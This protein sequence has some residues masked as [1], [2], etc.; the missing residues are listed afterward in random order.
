MKISQPL[1][2]SESSFIL[3]TME[4]KLLL[5]VV[6]CVAFQGF[7]GL[8]PV[9]RYGLFVGPSKTLVNLMAGKMTR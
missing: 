7:D 9:L 4:G 5:L 1:A 2:T 8:L 6:V 3:D